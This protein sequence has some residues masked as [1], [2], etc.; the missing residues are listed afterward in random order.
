MVG[1]SSYAVSPGWR[2][3]L[4]DLGLNP[5]DVLRRADLPDDLFAREKATLDTEEYFRLWLSMEAE[6]GDPC[7]PLRIGSSVSVEAFDPP[8]FAA[9]CSPD[10]NH[11]LM[12]LSHFK[13]LVAPMALDVD[14][15]PARTRLTLRWLDTAVD[16]PDALVAAEL[17]F[18]VQL[19]RIGSRSRVVPQEVTGPLRL[20][21]SG[22]YREYFGVGV[23]YASSPSI[24]FDAEDA[25]R[26]FLTANDKMWRFFEPDLQKRLCELDRSASTA[27]RARAALLEL[28]PSGTASVETVSKRL[29]VSARTLQ[30]RLNHEGR[31]FQRV[32]NE[33]REHL[34]R[35]YLRTSSISGAEISF[36][37]GFEDPNSF[38]RAFHDWTGTTPEQA[39]RALR[40]AR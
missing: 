12:R 15:T 21:P 38:F 23:A 31:S 5:G 29:G 9:L 14:V 4:H 30:R 37:L 33:T 13:R 28:L 7:L 1:A 39:R 19:A 3:L 2:V 32:L 20:E 16:P 6:S 24:S 8:I 25:A 40:S 26:P 27:E 34:A 36:L 22:E 17:V 35:H 18:F 11:A 10:L